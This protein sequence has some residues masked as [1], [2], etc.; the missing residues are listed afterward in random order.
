M[1]Q[2]RLL[3]FD[4][5]MTMAKLFPDLGINSKSKLETKNSHVDNTQKLSNAIS[6]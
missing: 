6:T 1:K 4:F 5:K 2:F 3:A